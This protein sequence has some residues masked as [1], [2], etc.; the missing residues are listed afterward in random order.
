MIKYKL[1]EVPPLKESLLF[2]LQWLAIASSILIIGGRIVAEIH[3]EDLFEIT[4]YIQK[5]FFI[6]GATL[7]VQIFFG[8]RL[9]MI[10]GPSAVLIVCIH[11]LSGVGVE[12]IYTAIAVCGLILFLFS[13]IGFGFLRKIFTENVVAAVFLLVSFTLIPVILNLIENLYDLI[14]STFLAVFLFA[15]SKKF[16]SNVIL[17]GLFFGSLAHFTIFPREIFLDTKVYFQLKFVPAFH[18]EVIL[19][20]FLCY[21]A[22][23]VNDL[24]SIYST[25]EMLKADRIEARVKSGL[26]V[27]G[28]SNFFSGILG[29]VG[30]VN[31]ALSPGMIGAMKCASRYVLA[32]AGIFLIFFSMF[33]HLILLFGAIPSSVIVSVFLYLICSQVAVVL[34]EVKINFDS[35]SVVVFPVVLALLLTILPEDVLNSLP[36]IFKLF[37]RN[38]FLIGILISIFMEHIVKSQK[39]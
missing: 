35:G 23:A 24:S 2:S 4:N 20:F 22:L 26:S 18:I 15:L 38:G 39:S 21:L 9:P 25:G 31:Y 28:L 27:T 19:I 13:F 3:Y 10:A 32:P 33:P 11:S 17:F 29:V 7:L 16:K 8:H 1:N 30:T 6:S 37:L 12:A 34:S 5:V 36:E 14:F